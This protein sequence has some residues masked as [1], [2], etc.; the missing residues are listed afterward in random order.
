MVTS[1]TGQAGRGFQRF[2]TYRIGQNIN[3]YGGVSVGRLIGAR[4]DGGRL[5]GADIWGHLGTFGAICGQL[6]AVG[7]LVSIC[8][9]FGDRYILIGQKF[10]RVE[11]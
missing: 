8:A 2:G 9:D 4:F 11:F 1:A 10:C 7:G 6:G 3:K 5:D